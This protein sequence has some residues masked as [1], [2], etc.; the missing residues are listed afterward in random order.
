MMA[1]DETQAAKNAS[2]AAKAVLEKIED[3]IKEVLDTPGASPE[4][5]RQA[6]EDV[7]TFV[8][9]LNVCNCCR[10]L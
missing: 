8:S 6:A 10:H 2:E 3:E 1:H 4:E 5:I 9:M 7:S